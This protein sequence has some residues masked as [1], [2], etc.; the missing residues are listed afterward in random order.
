MSNKRITSL[1]R[2]RI[3]ALALAA[4]TALGLSGVVSTTA[5]AV[6]QV[7]MLHLSVQQNARAVAVTGRSTLAEQRIHPATSYP[8]GSVEFLSDH[9]AWQAEN[10]LWVPLDTCAYTGTG[11]SAGAVA[12][13]HRG[14][15]PA[16][17]FAI[18]AE[19]SDATAFLAYVR[20]TGYWLLC[21][22][23][24]GCAN[25][26]QIYTTAGWESLDAYEAQVDATANAQ[27]QQV[28]QNYVNTVTPSLLQQEGYSRSVAVN[29]T[30]AA[31]GQ[32]D[33]RLGA[34]SLPWV[35]ACL[36]DDSTGY[37]D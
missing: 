2:Q 20:S 22:P 8:A 23:S 9:C 11:T 37:C 14:Q 30:V 13:F 36:V 1:T 28:Q 4:G 26:R 29:A 31:L 21:N 33:L 6:P 3:V 10:G 18:V 24:A 34:L 16:S 12:F 27:Q 35:G 32:V 19:S 25:T 17:Y 15:G 7:S 5:Q